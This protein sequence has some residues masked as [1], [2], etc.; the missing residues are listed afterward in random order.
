MTDA[1]TSVGDRTRNLVLLVAAGVLATVVVVLVLVF[2]VVRPPAL[3]SLVDEP[4]PAPSAA[5]AW[6]AYEQ[7]DGDCLHVARPDREV[8]RLACEVTGGMLVAWDDDGIVMTSWG[9]HD[10]LVWIDPVSGD[11][12]RRDR[13]ADGGDLDPHTQEV[14]TSRRRDGVLAV[15][16][17]DTGDVLWAVEAPDTYRVDSGTVSPDGDWIALV[18]SA[19]RLLVVPGDGSTAPRVWAEEVPTWTV[20]VWEG[21]R[22]GR[23]SGGG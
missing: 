5:V 23:V 18:D 9:Q 15:T 8:V 6:S 13:V 4:M 2:G 16:R 11:E 3:T 19:S 17:Q 22:H 14:V 20:P 1:T 10:E 21:T 7:D 12:V